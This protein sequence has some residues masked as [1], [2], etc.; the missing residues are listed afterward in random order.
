MRTIQV[1][2]A[3]FLIGVMVGLMT[4]KNCTPQNNC[5]TDTVTVHKTD[6]VIVIPPPET[7]EISIPTMAKETR[8]RVDSFIVYEYV[9]DSSLMKKYNLLAERYNQLF[10]DHNTARNYIDTTKFPNGKVVVESDVSANRLQRNKVS[11]LDLKQITVTNTIVNTVSEKRMIGYFGING[12]Y[13]PTDS[14]AYI[15]AAFR[16][17]FKNNMLL[18][19]GAKYS[20]RSNLLLEAEYGVP[21]H[22]GK[23][24]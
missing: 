2:I 1:T 11:L 5:T 10:L 7:R 9:V 16:L 14:T 12:G 18:G 8:P 19:I 3:F 21:I 22:L 23:R 15:G 4:C 24:K 17:K 6:T 13:Q 20:S